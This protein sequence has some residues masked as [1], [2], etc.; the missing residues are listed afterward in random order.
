[1]K[2]DQDLPTVVARF[3]IDR[4]SIESQYRRVMGEEGPYDAHLGYSLRAAGLSECGKYVEHYFHH[5]ICRDEVA[6]RQLQ[7]KVEAAG[8]IDKQWWELVQSDHIGQVPY[9]ATPEFAE[10]ERNGMPL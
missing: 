4:V 5:M 7:A 8:S 3:K 10:R 1:M 2:S 6:L 9:W